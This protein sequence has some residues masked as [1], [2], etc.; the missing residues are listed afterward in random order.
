MKIY[1]GIV[2]I[3]VYSPAVR[4]FT[5]PGKLGEAGERVASSSMS[6]SAVWLTNITF[7]SF[8]VACPMLTKNTIRCVA[9]VDVGKHWPSC[10]IIS[11]ICQFY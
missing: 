9:F 1:F 3:L 7:D 6:I 8:I 11:D 10:E 2:C 5:S 4:A